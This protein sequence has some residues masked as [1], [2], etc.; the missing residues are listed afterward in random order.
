MTKEEHKERLRLILL[1]KKEGLSFLQ[2]REL[3]YLN[4]R[5]QELV[6]KIQD[7]LDMMEKTKR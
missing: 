5:Y 6:N 2:G 7:S 3:K 1:A 4:D